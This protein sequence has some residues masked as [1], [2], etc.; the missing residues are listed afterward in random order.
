MGTEIG[1][2]NPH[3]S[4]VHGPGGTNPFEDNYAPPP[5]HHYGNQSHESPLGLQ[6]NPHAM[7]HASAP[8][9][10]NLPP[11]FGTPLP[12][13]DNETMAAIA[14]QR[15]QTA[16]NSALAMATAEAESA[17]GLNEFYKAMAE[18]KAKSTKSAGEKL[19]G[20]A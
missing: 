8:Q 17:Q 10:R 13:V 6:G 18:M 16:N 5:E 11:G 19:A 4:G 3:T 9:Q 20:L 14:M 15:Q 2:F 12:P 7:H 1:G